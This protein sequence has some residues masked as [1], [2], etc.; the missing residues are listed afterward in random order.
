MVHL[1]PLDDQRLM[2]APVNAHVAEGLPQGRRRE[3]LVAGHKPDAKQHAQDSLA[4]V[5]TDVI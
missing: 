2:V 4:Q 5:I 1:V 3:A